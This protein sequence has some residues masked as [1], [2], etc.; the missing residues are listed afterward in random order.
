MTDFS[1]KP[2]AENVPVQDK[3]GELAKAL[4]TKPGQS[5]PDAMEGAETLSEAERLLEAADAGLRRVAEA[6]KRAKPKG[7][8]PNKSEA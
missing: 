8:I 5:V 7:A 4:M 3:I 2:G 1:K 6:R